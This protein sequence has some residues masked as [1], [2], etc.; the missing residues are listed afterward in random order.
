[1]LCLI[2]ACN[3][4]PALWQARRAPP[5]EGHRPGKGS[6]AGE[7][8]HGSRGAALVGGLLWSREPR[9]P[10]RAPRRPRRQAQKH[11][12][13]WLRLGPLSP[14]SPSRFLC[15]EATRTLPHTLQPCSTFLSRDREATG[16]L[17]RGG[18]QGACPTLPLPDQEL[19]FLVRNTPASLTAR[20]REAGAH[21]L[22][23]P[24]GP[25]AASPQSAGSVHLRFKALAL[26]LL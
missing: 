21:A 14:P 15:W 10:A 26:C 8:G 16:L 18:L 25:P 11:R 1:M 9:P 2:T 3:L 17:N 24:P 20:G 12:V 19:A 4:G 22:F 13:S 6:E 5:R 7:G 23:T